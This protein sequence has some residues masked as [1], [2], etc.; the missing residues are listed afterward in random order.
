MNPLWGV[1][2]SAI[3]AVGTGLLVYFIMQSHMELMM[4]KQ[5]EELAATRA[6]LAAQRESLESTL[7]N[8][9]ET[10]R[11]KAMDAFLAEIR[12][13]ERHYTREHKVLF[14]SRKMLV[15]QERIFFRNI[16]LSNWVENEM[17]I[18][19]GVD[20]EKMAQ[21]MSVFLNAAMLGEVPESA[22]HKLLR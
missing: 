4:S 19:E 5:R 20:A 11:S 3:C 17:P 9:E 1:V 10:A 15:R 13:E 16:P 18:E 8:A 2:W 21:T 7:K 22:V 6:T 14:M 12:I